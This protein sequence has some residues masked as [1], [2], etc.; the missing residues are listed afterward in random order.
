MVVRPVTAPLSASANEGLGIEYA[1]LYLVH[2]PAPEKRADTWHAL[3]ELKERGKAR[4][5]VVEAYRPLARGIRM[6]DPNLVAVAQK[7]GKTPAQIRLRW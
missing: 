4:G 2:W 6:Q 5:I 7:Y 1:D 3:L